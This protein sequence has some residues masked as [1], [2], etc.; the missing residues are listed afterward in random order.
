VPDRNVFA[1]VVWAAIVTLVPACSN[2]GPDLRG[3]FC[4]RVAM[5]HTAL[6]SLRPGSI[7]DV[8]L[9]D[10][11]L[12]EMESGFG[13]D[14]TALRPRIPTLAGASTQLSRSIERLRMA[15]STGGNVTVAEED[16][17]TRVQQVNSRCV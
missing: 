8:Q 10:G 15:A 6:N 4:D 9:A 11:A 17:L 16:L 12:A 14:S 2:A 3:P 7:T 13:R 1:I 5:L